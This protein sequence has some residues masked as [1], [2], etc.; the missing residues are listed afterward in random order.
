M[1]S[2]WKLGTTGSLSTNHRPHLASALSHA[3]ELL[4]PAAPG[5]TTGSPRWPHTRDGRVKGSPRST[6]LT[7]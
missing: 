2:P 5:L 3:H 1:F 7:S 4:P 6:A